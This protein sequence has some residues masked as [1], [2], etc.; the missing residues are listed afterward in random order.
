MSAVRPRPNRPLLLA[1]ALLATAACRGADEADEGPPTIADQ[2]GVSRLIG[3]SNIVRTEA[4]DDATAYTFGE[5]RTGCMRGAPFTASTE[6][7]R[8]DDLVIFLQGG[9]A[10]WSD[11]CFAVTA[12]GGGVPRLDLLNPD[13]AGNPVADWDVTY[14][15]YCDGSLFAGDKDHDDDGDGQ[16]DRWHRGL[17]NLSA[18]LDVAKADFPDPP[19]VLLAGSSGGGFGSILATPLV[20]HVFPDAEL[21]VI[22]DSGVG[23][24]RGDADP[25]Y[26]ERLI[27]EFG[28]EGVIP[29]DCPDCIADGHIMGLVDWYLAQDDTVRMG[30]FSAWY[31]SIIAGVFLDVEPGDFQSDMQTL[32]GAIHEQHPD[33]YRRFFIDGTMHTTLIG[34]PSGVIGDK[35]DAVELPVEV[36]TSLNDLELGRM[37]TTAIGDTTVLDWVAAFVDGD[38]AGWVDIQETPGPIPEWD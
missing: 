36:L 29:E 22:N 11:F 2:L 15:P 3:T 5:D 33:R 17:A 12:A 4:V 23:I 37:Q 25:G 21:M 9:G 34:D 32:T 8:G 19:R 26:V 16:T 6:D 14:V 10:C 27:G 13:I 30:V 1:A 7:R 38:D 18:A 24:A 20:R 28:A 31:D 35:L